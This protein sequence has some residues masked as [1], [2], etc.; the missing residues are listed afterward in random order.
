MPLSEQEIEALF[1][2]GLND[3]QV[4]GLI[5]REDRLDQARADRAS[6][7]AQ[8][9][10]VSNNQG[11]I[12]NLGSLAARTVDSL[13]FG[14]AAEGAALV[15][16]GLER[17]GIGEERDFAD[18]VAQ[19]ERNLENLTA[20]N[21]ITSAIGEGIGGALPG[22]ATGGTG[23]LARLGVGG[24]RAN[25]VARTAP[26]LGQVIRNSTA[27]GAAGGFV[28][29]D[30][31]IGRDGNFLNLS[32]RLVNSLGGGAIGL[33]S[34]GLLG[35]TS[36]LPRLA[37][38]FGGFS[39]RFDEVDNFLANPEGLRARARD[40]VGEATRRENIA[41]TLIQNQQRDLR[42]VQDEIESQI[43]AKPEVDI[44]DLKRGL[45]NISRNAVPKN[46]LNNQQRLDGE[47]VRSVIDRLKV[48]TEVVDRQE[49]V[50]DVFGTPIGTRT[51]QET[52]DTPLPDVVSGEVADTLIKTIRNLNQSGNASSNAANNAIQSAQGLVQDLQNTNIGRP[53]LERFRTVKRNERN[54]ADIVRDPTAPELQISPQARGVRVENFLRGARNT[55][56]NSRDASLIRLDQR[57]PQLNLAQ[58]ALDSSTIR[59][60]NN[61]S[62]GISNILTSIG[63]V[64]RGLAA[65]SSEAFQN[66]APRANSILSRLNPALSPVTTNTG[67]A[68]LLNRILTGDVG[69]N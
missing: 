36:Q 8:L 62:G 27:L 60:I 51:V 66:V 20:A 50:R 11:I 42:V 30:G 3:S 46:P 18:R 2:A 25:N 34:S 31:R 26:R 35:L 7:Q 48:S 55:N 53:T 15:S 12:G 32:Q 59:N 19:G 10:A 1:D 65:A 61:P 44:T 45:D 67:T 47:Q 37:G 40:S 22:I 21:P 16:E 39:P 13:T 58:E 52:V 68:A 43:R 57:T 29:D 56:T 4:A 41:E 17:L 69:E 6:G 14:N 49:I 38:R 24:A 54:L 33:G 63:P 64:G 23:L 28:A 5:E 9:D